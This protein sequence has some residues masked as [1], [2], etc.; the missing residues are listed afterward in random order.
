MV[1]EFPDLCQ[2]TEIVAEITAKF[3]KRALLIP[4]CVADEDMKKMRYHDML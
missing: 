1:R 4:L 2:M 3:R